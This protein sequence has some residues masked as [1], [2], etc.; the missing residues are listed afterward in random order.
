MTQIPTFGLPQIIAFLVTIFILIGGAIYV[1]SLSNKEGRLQP[2]H[3]A[4]II[5]AWGTLNFLTWGIAGYTSG[6][7]FLESGLGSFKII[8]KAIPAIIRAML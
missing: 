4:A 3:I 7:Q 1:Q 2:S 8:V 6:D 5:G